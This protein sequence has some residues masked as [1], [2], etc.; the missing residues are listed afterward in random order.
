MTAKRI[1]RWMVT[2]DGCRRDYEISAVEGWS[3]TQFNAEGWATF[4]ADERAAMAQ[5][6]TVA[7]V[8]ART[9]AATTHYCPNCAPGR[10]Q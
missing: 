6:G 1:E 4:E 2:C 10:G 9:E 5:G 3:P 7:E 8:I